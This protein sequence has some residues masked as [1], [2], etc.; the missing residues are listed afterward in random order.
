M[1]SWISW[2]RGLRGLLRFARTAM[3]VSDTLARIAENA[4]RTHRAQGRPRGGSNTAPATIQTKIRECPH[5]DFSVHDES[6]RTS[7]EASQRRGRSS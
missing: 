3:E 6:R 5:S 1:Q 4:K 7:I 2:P